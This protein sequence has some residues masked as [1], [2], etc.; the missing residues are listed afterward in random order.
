MTPQ[1]QKK[2]KE[3]FGELVAIW[4]S[5][6]SDT[7]KCNEW[8][9]IRDRDFCLVLGTRSAIFAPLKNLKLL[10]VDEEQD[11]SFEADGKPNL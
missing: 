5:G 11:S 9:K 1:N 6:L 3:H 10:I 8:L 2:F 4:H 7:E